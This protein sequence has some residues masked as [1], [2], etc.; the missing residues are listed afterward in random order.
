[1]IYLFFC[2]FSNK[3][4]VCRGVLRVTTFIKLK[5]YW[6]I[7]IYWVFFNNNLYCSYN[8]G[9]N[10]SKA[11]FVMSPRYSFCA[12]LSLHLL[13]LTLSYVSLIVLLFYLFCYYSFRFLF[14]FCFCLPRGRFQKNI[15]F[16][17]NNLTSLFLY[18]VICL[19]VV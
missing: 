17:M 7:L 8:E 1:M 13:W 14:C 3:R 2:I 10:N 12:N 19:L 16:W 15:F 5:R 9:V 18:F 4:A 6:N 11:G